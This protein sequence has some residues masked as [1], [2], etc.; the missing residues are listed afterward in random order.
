M[1]GWMDDAWCTADLEEGEVP[2][3]A[4][5]PQSQH[6][7]QLRGGDVEGGR[8]GEGLDDGLR[9]VGG[10]EAQPQH[11]HAHLVHSGLGLAHEGFKGNSGD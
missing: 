3:V 10:E 6:A 1:D 2:R 9:Q 11:K 5:Q 8:A 4:W 7:L